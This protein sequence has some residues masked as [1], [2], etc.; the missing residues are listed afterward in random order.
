MSPIFLPRWDISPSCF[1]V[2]P[3][4]SLR[5][6]SQ[7]I[8]QRRLTITDRT[9]I[10]GGLAQNVQTPNIQVFLLTLP[11]FQRSFYVFLPFLN[12]FNGK[13]L[14][15]D[16]G[17][18]FRWWSELLTQRVLRLSGQP[19]SESEY[20]I[21]MMSHSGHHMLRFIIIAMFYIGSNVMTWPYEAQRGLTDGK[22][23]VS[24]HKSDFNGPIVL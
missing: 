2:S 11:M 15:T 23:W 8:F 9:R 17:L 7:E 12:H 22:S 16:F 24:S 20:V 3:K 1:L 19:K 13:I 4:A 18:W 14:A 21:V 10:A 6:R 5:E